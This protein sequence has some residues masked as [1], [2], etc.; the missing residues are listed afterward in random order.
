MKIDKIEISNYCSLKDVT[1]H[2]KNIL[3]LVGRNNSG[4]SN[5]LK[6][7][8]LFFESSTKLVSSEYFCN[9]ETKVPIEIIVTFHQL[10]EWEKDQFS[11]WMDEDRLVVGREIIC[12]GEDSHEINTIAIV[13]VPEPEWLREDKM[14]GDKIIE[15]WSKRQEMHVNNLDFAAE[16]GSS[17]PS[18]GKWKET[19]SKFIK[20]HRDDIPWTRE[21]LQNPKG[22]PNVLKGSLPEFILIPA[23]RDITEEAKVGKTN[24][25]GQLINS[26]L[27]K[28]SIEQKGVIA[29]KLKE[30]ENLLNRSE[31]EGRITE[32][33]L[34]ED[35]LNQLMSEIMDCDIE[36]SMTMPRLGDV[37]GEAKLYANDGIRTTI[38][39][40]GHG[41]QRSMIFTILRAYAE[42]SH[43]RKAGDKFGERNAIFAIEE[44]ELYLHPQSQRT[45]MSVFRQIAGGRDQIIYC[46]QSSLFVDISHFEEICIMRRERKG[47]LFESHPTQLYISNLIEDLWNRKKIRADEEGIREQYSHAF[48]P[49]INE[50][51]FADKVIIVEG[52]SEQYSLPIYASCLEYDLDR[53]NVAVVHSEGKGQMDRLWRIFT[54]F[55]IP[56]FL[57]FDGDKKSNKSNIKQKTLELL[58]LLGSPLSSIEE[59]K[60]LVS[61]NFAVLENKY[62]D[63]LREELPDFDYLLGEAH[64]VLGPSGKPLEHRFIARTL[65]QRVTQGEDAKGVLPK[66][67]IRIVERIKALS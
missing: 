1:I 61:D 57:W 27:E 3:A 64:E 24:P 39:T 8:Q 56:T 9:H 25:F 15:W 45:L 52:P 63:T 12:L 38:E 10:S 40:K 21:R 60:T 5:V 20:E 54:G 2:P 36:I 34:I 47:D 35:R 49:L 41:M 19:I 32:I 43:L 55:R 29:T 6:A 17:K 14:N 13:R 37:F 51:F 44:P 23:V 42:F 59:L 65:K 67:V 58:E 22:Y 46:T 48:N 50:G 7:L 30:I 66:I 33:K 11:A 53:N 28:I 16:L 62:E 26:V 31:K 4:K 18:V